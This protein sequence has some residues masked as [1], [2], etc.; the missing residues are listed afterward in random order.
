MSDIKF[1][2]LHAGETFNYRGETVKVVGYGSTGCGVS[3]IVEGTSIGWSSFD[4]GPGDVILCPPA[5]GE[6]VK[7]GYVGEY[8]LD[9]VPDDTPVRILIIGAP[10]K[11]RTKITKQVSKDY[12]LPIMDEI[13]TL[14]HIPNE[15]GVYVSR[16]IDPV[17]AAKR[18]DEF[19][20]IIIM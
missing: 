14:D 10:G 18:K 1:A 12:R 19:K 20:L 17:E 15:K 7:Y 8:D 3:I 11:D 16:D 13:P 9:G 2:K 6:E 4:L 5:E